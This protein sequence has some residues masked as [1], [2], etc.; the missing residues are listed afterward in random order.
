MHCIA[1]LTSVPEAG[2]EAPQL[3]R[4]EQDSEDCN[5]AGEA[6]P[7]REEDGSNTGLEPDRRAPARGKKRP[8]HG[9]GDP[10]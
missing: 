7:A 1:A 8:R 6:A 10:G 3:S 2:S 9:L 4:N 5:L